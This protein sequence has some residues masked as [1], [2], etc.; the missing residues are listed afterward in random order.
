MA[1]EEFKKNF[2]AAAT[3]L[4][5][6]KNESV[7]I[8]ELKERVE[9][10]TGLNA[11]LSNT[12]NGLSNRVRNLEN[13]NQTLMFNIENLSHRINE[14]EEN[15]NVYESLEK[16]SL[17][18]ETEELYDKIED[19]NNLNISLGRDNEKLIEEN[20]ILKKKIKELEI[21][22]DSYQ[23]CEH[24]YTATELAAKLH[25]IGYFGSIEK[26]SDIWNDGTVVGIETN[27]IEI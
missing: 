7:K 20:E 27:R 9:F 10:L 16:E 21:L 15:L 11:T 4:N 19:L 17:A 2:P 1:K 3:I 25:G 26:R 18:K 6:Y 5:K 12:N 24:E 8:K 22:N 14:L 13:T 23:N